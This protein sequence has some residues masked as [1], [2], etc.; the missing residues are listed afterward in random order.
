MKTVLAFTTAIIFGG[1]LGAAVLIVC[2]D[3]GS[4]PTAAQ[5]PNYAAPVIDG[6][7]DNEA[8]PA[9]PCCEGQR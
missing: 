9:K 4:Q 7:L 5:W 8:P 3:A 2:R 6:R 1:L